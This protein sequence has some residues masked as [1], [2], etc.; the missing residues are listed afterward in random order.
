MSAA[1][2]LAGGAHPVIVVIG[3]EAA[4]SARRCG[5]SVAILPTLVTP[6]RLRTSLRAGCEAFRRGI[7]GTLILLGD[8]PRSRLQCSPPD[9]CLHRAGATCPCATGA[10][11][12]G[13]GERHFAEM[14]QLTAG[15]ARRAF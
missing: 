8:M 11:H 13:R 14:M 7:D 4:A 2:A 9:G 5:G 10:R 3:H 15:Q 6:M 12:P 1:T